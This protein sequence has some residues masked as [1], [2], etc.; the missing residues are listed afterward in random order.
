MNAVEDEASHL[1]EIALAEDL[2]AGDLTTQWTVPG[3]LHGSAE[4]VAKESLVLAG[5]FVAQRAFLGVDPELEV[6][7]LQEEGTSVPEGACVMQ[8]RGK[9]GAILTGE[10]TAL[11]FLA[12]LSG[13]ATLTREFVAAVAGTGA[14]ITDTRK[15]TPGWRHLEKWAVRLGGGENHRLG[16]YDM[17]LVKDNHIAAAG[18][19]R[20]ATRRVLENNDGRLSVE[21]EV[22]HPEE[23]EE[24]RDLRV[25]RILLDN[26]NDA[27]LRK[28]VAR[29][30]RWPAPRPELEASGNMTLERVAAV[31]QTGVDW[32]SVGAL[33]HSARAADF[34]LRMAAPEAEE[35]G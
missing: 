25:N 13:I 1:V 7:V 3:D 2:G 31:A 28:A 32:I 9:V 14:K 23:V 15:T 34:S 30:S 8:L 5:A 21:V 20:E 11:N 6:M 24:L 4:I 10:R 17:I 29:V 18:G 19:V 12:R 26:M 22:L 27:D 35:K 16:L 33:T